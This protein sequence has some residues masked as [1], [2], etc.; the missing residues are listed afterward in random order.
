MTLNIEDR[1]PA[2][3]ETTLIRV[4]D[5]PVRLVHWAIVAI[6]GFSWWTASTRNLEWHRYSGYLLAS[7]LLF[8]LYWGIVGGTNARF[9]SFVRGPAAA[10]TYLRKGGT[11][12]PIGGHNPVG[13]WSAIA[14][15]LMM[16]VQIATGLVSVDVDGIE[17]GPFSY[18][19]GFE[20]GRIAAGI[21]ELSFTILQLL[22][23]A[24]I[25]AILYY[26]V[27]RRQNL[28]AAMVN[29]HKRL[30]GDAQPPKT[31][32]RSLLALGMIAAAA[33]AFYLFTR[34]IF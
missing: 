12:S 22:I 19:L 4:W 9:A 3:P 25:L 16:L 7:L 24:H 1:V 5:A 28:T 21:H 33:L 27:V 8:R 15:L 18:L 20:E 26:L 23:G 11:R 2:K 14:M 31:G 30:P 6:V 10:W 17:S 32:R 13:G 29:G 34:P